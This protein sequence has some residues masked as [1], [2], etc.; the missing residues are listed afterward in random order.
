MPRDRFSHVIAFDD[1]PFPHDHRG[2]VLVVGVACSG[3]RLEG[4]LSTRVRRD[5]ANAT[6]ALAARVAASRFA[7]HT[8]LLLLQGIALGGFNVVDIHALHAA[9]GIPVL[10]VARRPPR[11]AAIRAAL[12]GHVP[13]G[14]RKWALIEK[15]GAME[16]CGGLMAQ[17]AGITLEE[18]AAVITRLAVNG[19]IPEPLRVAHLIAGGVTTGESRGRA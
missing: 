16:A 11:L 15:A 13:G 10:V 5:G 14:A 3:A 8:R 4:V 6:R 1:A 12:L 19:A 17:R 7:G 18:A 2:D 9:L